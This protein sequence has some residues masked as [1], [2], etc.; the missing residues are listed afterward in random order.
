MPAD[1]IRLVGVRVTGL[2]DEATLSR[3][4]IEAFLVRK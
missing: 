2:R 4:S 3:N 1:P